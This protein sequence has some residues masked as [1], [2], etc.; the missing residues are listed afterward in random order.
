MVCSY[1]HREK[2]RLVV[3]G[4]KWQSTILLASLIDIILL[5]VQIASSDSS[6]D[7]LGINIVT[8]LVLSWYLLDIA[9]RLYV[10]H[11][12]LFFKNY[13]NVFFDLGFDFDHFFRI[14][15]RYNRTTHVV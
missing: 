12:Y 3:I 9:I 1:T 4:L 14:S 5:L 13:A 8:W 6:Q 7:D 11:L 2:T 10:F 15:R